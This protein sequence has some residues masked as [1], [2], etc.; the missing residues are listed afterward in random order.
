MKIGI[1]GAGPIGKTFAKHA[2]KSGYEVLISNSRGPETLVDLVKEIGH[3][4]KPVTTKEVLQ[5]EIIFLAVNFRQ[6]PNLVT[7]AAL[8]KG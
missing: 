1:I 8:L 3:G 4:I 2:A 6:V 5:A 7:D